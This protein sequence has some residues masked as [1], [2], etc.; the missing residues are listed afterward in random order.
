VVSFT[1]R[2]LY[3]GKRAPGTHWIG[4]GVGPRAGLDDV[5]KR[6]F[7]PPPGL[8]LR[9]L[10][11]PARRQ[12]LYRLRYPGPLYRILLRY[13]ATF[14]HINT[15]VFHIML[16]TFLFLLFILAC[17]EERKCSNIDVLSF[18]SNSRPCAIS[19]ASSECFIA[20]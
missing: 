16:L 13:S 18:V 10:G 19:V 4:G 15:F 11:D 12:S 14:S 1:P 6:K 9:P 3:P 7:F 20:S 5:E 8:E 2:Q 17:F